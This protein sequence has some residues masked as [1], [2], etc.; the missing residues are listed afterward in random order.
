MYSV[1][2]GN[3]TL[4]AIIT[5]A[6]LLAAPSAGAQLLEEVIVAAQNGP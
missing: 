4:Y 5:C 2:S 1:K 6:M 3:V